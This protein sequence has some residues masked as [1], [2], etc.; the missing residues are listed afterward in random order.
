MKN[1]VL[2]YTTEEV[3]RCNRLIGEFMGLIFLDDYSFKTKENGII[4]DRGHLRYFSDWNKL[5][6]VINKIE[7]LGANFE[8][9]K[10]NSHIAWWYSNIKTKFDFKEPRTPFDSIGGKFHAR[11]VGVDRTAEKVNCETKLQAN[12]NNVVYFIEWY[13]KTVLKK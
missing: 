5:M 11:D 8:I 12:Y 13:N 1:K 2:K 6:D 3:V 4:R 10:H 7:I 9:R